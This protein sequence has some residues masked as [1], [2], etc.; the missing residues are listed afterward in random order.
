M[1][2][3][4]YDTTKEDIENY[5][6]DVG[7]IIKLSD[8]IFGQNYKILYFAYILSLL[9]FILQIFTID[10]FLIRSFTISKNC[11]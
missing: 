5:A 7:S 2:I 8:F 1:I 9:L 4:I 3:S 6:I 10:N 11:F